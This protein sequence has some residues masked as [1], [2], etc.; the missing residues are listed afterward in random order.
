MYARVCESVCGCVQVCDSVCE[1]SRVYESV[2][3]YASVAS[4]LERK[5][6]C[7]RECVRECV[8]VCDIIIS[9]YRVELGYIQTDAIGFKSSL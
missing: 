4:V 5:I 6:V 8:L 9:E 3:E 1:C 2:C 7:V